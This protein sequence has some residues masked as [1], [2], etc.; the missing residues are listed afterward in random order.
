MS[1]VGSESRAMNVSTR[2]TFDRR[3]LLAFLAIALASLTLRIMLAPE[4]SGLDDA[5][6]LEA[7][8]HVS[9]GRSLD[10]LLPLF[11]FRVGMAYPLGWAMRHSILR[12]D[13]FWVLTTAAAAITF[14][15]LFVSATQLFGTRAGPLC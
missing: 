12:P 4:V 14:C 2:P 11:R 6:Y 3:S 1:H 15:A 13:Q 9:D 8:Q 10:N 7:A 5:G